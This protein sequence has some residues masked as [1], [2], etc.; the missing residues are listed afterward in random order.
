MLARHVAFL[1]EEI[2][3]RIKNNIV[4]LVLTSNISRNTLDHTSAAPEQ[5]YGAHRAF[6]NKPPNVAP[7]PPSNVKVFVFYFY[8]GLTPPVVWAPGQIS[9]LPP[10][11]ERPCEQVYWVRA[12]GVHAR[13]ISD[14]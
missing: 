14:S 11:S 2:A 12:I 6:M 13:T 3:I 1:T 8:H 9:F 4:Q 7:C 5:V 10:L